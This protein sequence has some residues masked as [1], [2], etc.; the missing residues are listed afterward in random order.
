MK[1][2]IRDFISDDKKIY[3]TTDEK[4]C[5]EEA[6]KI[7]LAEDGIKYILTNREKHIVCTDRLLV[8]GSTIY[9]YP[10][11]SNDG[12][13]KAIIK[14]LGK[15][16][17]VVAGKCNAST[18]KRKELIAV[19]KTLTLCNPESLINVYCI[20]NYIQNS[21]KYYENIWCKNNWQT[22][23]QANVKNKDLL[24]EL[25]YLNQKLHIQYF[26]C[27]PKTAEIFEIPNKQGD[28]ENCGRSWM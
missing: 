1:T 18:E 3:I 28:N 5:V 25:V 12:Q 26:Q 19:V 22:V 8:T 10:Q 9:I 24:E 7:I 20:S 6:D 16:E 23:E 13:F 21:L 2:K 17:I 4:I 27:Q 11:I 15:A 14:R